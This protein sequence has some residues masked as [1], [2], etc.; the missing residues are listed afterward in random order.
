MGRG[1]WVGEGVENLPCA[2][3]TI[4]S[5][6]PRTLLL[7]LRLEPLLRESGMEWSRL[8]QA[9]GVRE[10]EVATCSIEAEERA[11]T[12]GGLDLGR[13]ISMDSP[14]LPCQRP[15]TQE[16][17]ESPGRTELRAGLWA[18]VTPLCV[19]QWDE[20]ASREGRHTQGLCIIYTRNWVNQLYTLGTERGRDSKTGSHCA[21]DACPESPGGAA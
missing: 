2:R 20:R 19:V 18:H 7:R 3:G 8:H 6:L 16:A 12:F 5:G 9:G 17:A 21:G 4:G 14:P 10:E 1:T 11:Q 15:V 13:K